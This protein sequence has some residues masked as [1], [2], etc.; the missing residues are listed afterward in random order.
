[1]PLNVDAGCADVKNVGST[2]TRCAPRVEGLGFTVEGLVSRVDGVG[3]LQL[4]G[5]VTVEG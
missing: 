3:C 4:R 5:G 1:M 2:D